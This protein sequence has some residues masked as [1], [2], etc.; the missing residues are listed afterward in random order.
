VVIFPDG[1]VL[2][3]PDTGALATKLGLMTAPSRDFYDVIVIGA[4]PAGLA[5]ALYCSTEGLRTVLV[6]REAAGGQ[7]G[8]SSRIENY[9]GFP[10]GLSGADLA[11]RGV[12]QVRRFGTELLAP[13]RAVKLTSDN[14]YR[15]VTLDNGKELV[16]HSVVIASGVQWRR[17]EIAGM[18]SLTGAGV[19]YGAAITEAASCQDEDV[20]VVG[21]ANSA[22]QAAVHFSEF[23]RS[24]TMLV[25]ADSLSKS[26]S[27]YLVER[28]KEI[29]NIAVVPNAEVSRVEGDGS[30][31][32]IY[33]Q[34]HDLGTIEER[35]A[36]ALFV[37]IGAE[38]HT[39]WLDGT[40][41]RDQRGFLLTG[42]N[43][44]KN[45]K[46]PPGWTLQRDPYLLETNMPGVFAVGDVRD[47]AV[48]RV[49]NSVGEG[50][51]VLYFI[52]QHLANR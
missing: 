43:L 15:I 7:A 35:N 14:E 51:I 42:Q 31:A 3:R 33:I 44:L 28:I 4:G 25:R 30:L 34:R 38:P 41:V 13:A 36:R 37:F 46:R 5:C 8:L 17:L 27:H 12:A 52:R 1:T 24:V 47:G 32:K 18:D 2:E 39:Q 49:A 50:S 19:Y 9:L 21:G 22:G 16:A 29:P 26:M 23:A 48:R 45:G 6:E 20:F 40:L 11:R 10:S